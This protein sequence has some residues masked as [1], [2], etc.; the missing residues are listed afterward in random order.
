MKKEALDLKENNERFVGEV[1]YQ[2]TGKSVSSH[3]SAAPPVC[4]SPCL[5]LQNFT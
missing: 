5:F 3:V 4:P 2:I 1:G